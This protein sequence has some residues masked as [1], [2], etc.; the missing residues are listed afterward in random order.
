VGL[1]PRF[2]ALWKYDL[3]LVLGV[4]VLYSEVIFGEARVIGR[5]VLHYLMPIGAALQAG[6]VGN[7]SLLWDTSVDHGIP[8]IAR[9]SPMVFYP[10]QWLN[11]VFNPATAITIG[12]ILHLML[13]AFATLRLALRYTSSISAAWVA[14]FSFAY[15]GYLISVSVG[16]GYLFGAALL[17]LSLLC[18]HRLA[19]LPTLLRMT[20]CA[21][22]MALQ[23]FCADPQT[24]LYEG[25]FVVP[26]ILLLHHRGESALV[27]RLS[28]AVLA[29]AF[30]V[31]L[32]ACQLLPSFEFSALSVRA[33]GIATAD[34]E[35]WA[36]HPLRIVQF[37]SPH[38]LGAVTPQNT[39]WARS[40]VNARV[41]IPWAPFMY[42]GLLVW[43]GIVALDWRGPSRRALTLGAL[44]L[45]FL[46]V[47][48]GPW[49]PMYQ[50]VTGVLPG[51]R[52]FRYPE[53]LMLFVA[54]GICL[55]GAAGLGALLE[56]LSSDEAPPTRRRLRV[57]GVF[58]LFAALAACLRFWLEPSSPARLEWFASVLTRQHLDLSPRLVLEMVAS[59]LVHSAV[60]ASTITGICLLSR[61]IRPPLLMGLGATVLV[62]DIL[63]ASLTQRYVAE[64]ASYAGVPSACEALAPDGS[65]VLP[66]VWR[67]VTTPAVANAASPAVPSVPAE[68]QPPRGEPSQKERD[69]ARFERRRIWEFETLKPNIGSMYCV[70][71]ADAYESGRLRSHSLLATAMKDDVPR[72]LRILGVQYIIA[73]PS[74]LNPETFPV[75]VNSKPLSTTI[76]RVPDPLPYAHATGRAERADDVPG[77]IARLSEPSFDINQSIVLER[78]EPPTPFADAERTAQVRLHRPGEIVVDVDFSAAGYLTLEETYYPGWRAEVG[79]GT[80]AV[81]RANG[82]F[83]GVELPPG[84]YAV[85]FVFDPPVQ[86]R[87][88]AISLVCL[89]MLALVIAGAIASQRKSRRLKI[90]TA[91]AVTTTE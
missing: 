43:A 70:R 53:K 85:R 30:A 25:A 18:F 16:G 55:L 52:M 37:F 15:G 26:L 72:L 12:I 87:A 79:G 56:A 77:A 59:S 2:K 69:D 90:N 1:F 46:G 58:G 44:T 74:A 17:P 48:A 88:N 60:I 10:A 34:S 62:A 47:A 4:V 40:L 78:P 35:A 51:A 86:R 80:V 36:F 42:N 49:T 23:V 28:M 89:A 11:A 91:S 66:L 41:T 7:G 32:S 83:I 50:L 75:L 76:Q 45:F 57:A 8:V 3:A 29:T 61:R 13:A 24:L 67:V 84:K 39:F 71:Y 63:S 73:A 33:Q 64:T 20:Q 9:W 65:G 21:G 38:I 54:L 68:P 22:V 81:E 6:F 27:R 14:A 5:D 31:G 19:E 82:S